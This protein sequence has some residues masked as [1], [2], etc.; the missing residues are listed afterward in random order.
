MKYHALFFILKKQQNL[1]LSSAVKIGGTL[2]VNFIDIGVNDLL[3]SSL[4]LIQFPLYYLV[5]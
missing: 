2:R 1:K 4:P 5:H 3:F